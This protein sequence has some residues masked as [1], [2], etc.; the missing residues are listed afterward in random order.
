MHSNLSRGKH[1]ITQYFST[2]SRS[3]SVAQRVRFLA[4]G[5][6]KSATLFRELVYLGQEEV[7]N[8]SLTLLIDEL[9]AQLINEL[10]FVVGCS[11]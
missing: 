1:H 2:G 8:E 3:P 6:A 10:P 11:K 5:M 4:L 7:G 9:N